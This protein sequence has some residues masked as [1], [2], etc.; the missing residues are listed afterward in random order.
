MELNAEI[1]KVFG[2]EMAK[3]FATQISEDEMHRAAGQAWSML[4]REEWINGKHTTALKDLTMVAIKNNL[5]EEIKNITNSEEFKDECKKLAEE[6]VKDI[7]EETHKKV[8]EEVSNRL[9]GMSLGYQGI[10]LAGLIEETVVNM[11]HR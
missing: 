5:A 6:I 8:V 2:Q 10:G 1:N 9:A 7:R 11:M 3:L 4:N